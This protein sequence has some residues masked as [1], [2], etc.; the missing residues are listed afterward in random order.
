M[1]YNPDEHGDRGGYV[2]LDYDR[3]GSV[4]GMTPSWRELG[5][6]VALGIVAGVVMLRP[7]PIASQ[8][9]AVDAPAAVGR[10]IERANSR[11]ALRAVLHDLMPNLPSTR[12]PDP[13]CD[14]ST[15]EACAWRFLGREALRKSHRLRDSEA[16]RVLEALALRREYADI[17]SAC[18]DD[19]VQVA[20][21]LHFA[22]VRRADPLVAPAS[23]CRLD[24]L[25][26]MSSD[27]PEGPHWWVRVEERRGR[28]ATIDLIHRDHSRTSAGLTDN[29]FSSYELRQ[30]QSE[31]WYVGGHV[32]SN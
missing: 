7:E 17:D 10:R 9:D 26:R 25:A 31:W 4:V 21:L 15:R 11:T 18:F 22:F 5:R 23:S 24:G 28:A 12:E 13:V 30:R 8:R 3:S 16:R 6:A 29:V 20:L 27:R 19:P 32:T 1:D 14:D 2:W